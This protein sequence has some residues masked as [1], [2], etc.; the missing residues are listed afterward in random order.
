MGIDF[1]S[2][3]LCCFYFDFVALQTNPQ[4]VSFP[5]R[6][7]A[8]PKPVT[9]ASLIVFVHSKLV[10]RQFVTCNFYGF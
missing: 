1:R 7:C 3:N 5:F 10:F 6:Y 4:C 8:G 2:A 9:F